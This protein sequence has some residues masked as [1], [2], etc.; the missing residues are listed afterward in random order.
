MLAE[1]G[2]EDEVS[3]SVVVVVVP[4][5]PEG[6]V[7]VVL[8]VV[9]SVSVSPSVAQAARDIVATARAAAVRVRSVAFMVVGPL[10]AWCK[11]P[12]DPTRGS[13]GAAPRFGTRL[14]AFRP[15]Q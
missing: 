15:D 6:S 3:V 12:A 9:D 13:T 4:V 11:E 1:G 10:S 14:S 5:V 8:S 2:I 7:V